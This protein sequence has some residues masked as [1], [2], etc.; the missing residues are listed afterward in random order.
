MGVAFLP[1]M[2]LDAKTKSPYF[3]VTSILSSSKYFRVAQPGPR[4]GPIGNANSRQHLHEAA[5]QV[6]YL[7]IGFGSF[8]LTGATVETAAAT[9]ATAASVTVLTASEAAASMSVA[10]LAITFSTAS[11][12]GVTSSYTTT[13]L[14]PSSSKSSSSSSSISSGIG[15]CAPY[16]CFGLTPKIRII[17]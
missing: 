7:F 6:Q 5:A 11:S 12:A 17:F 1:E 16:S 2:V 3:I 10:S 14:L 8:S 4:S 9:A 13:S 15:S